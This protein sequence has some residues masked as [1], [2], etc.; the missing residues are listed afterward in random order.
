MMVT[1]YAYRQ[2]LDGNKS[3][4]TFSQTHPKLCT[5]SKPVECLGKIEL[6]ELHYTER[7][8]ESN[9]ESSK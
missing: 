3:F 8:T 7:L 5:L 2:I 6:K 4:I 9:D 1:L